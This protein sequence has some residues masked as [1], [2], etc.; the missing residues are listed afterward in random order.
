MNIFS[1][2]IIGKA[3][4]F[5]EALMVMLTILGIV[6]VLTMGEN[7][8]FGIS[9]LTL[10][11]DDADLLNNYT[12][13]RLQL[14]DDPALQPQLLITETKIKVENTSLFQ[15]PIIVL[16]LFLGAFSFTVLEQLRRM[17]KTVEEGNPFVTSN[18][19]K[20]QV[21][22]VLFMLV[23]VLSKILLEMMDA[24]IRATFEFEGLVLQESSMSAYPWIFTGFL[25]L[26]IGKI[27]SEGIAL[28]EEQELTI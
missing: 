2:K 20:I 15:F 9:N 11:P 23:P 10:V 5:F 21:L 25:F 13:I 3:V 28:R 7:M 18:V 19:R 16:L 22:A 26:T 27:I 24:W 17:V 1:F 8:D 14:K 6:M 12:D 4:V